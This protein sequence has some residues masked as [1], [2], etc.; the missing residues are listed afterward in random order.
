[1][2][3]QSN[4]DLKMPLG[5]GTFRLENGQAKAS[6]SMALDAGYRHIDTAQIYNNEAEVGEALK[7]SAINRDEIFLTTK[8]WNCHLNQSSF[9][10]S[11]KDSL[12]KL[13]TDHVD[14][15]LIHWPAPQ[16]NESM[17]EYLT[18]LLSA[19]QQGLSKHIG[20]S[21]F[22]IANLK[23]AF[24]T[25]APNDLFTNQVEV[26]PYL[27][28]KIL[29]NFCCNK[30]IHITSYMPFAYGKV[31][32]DPV[33]L[34]LAEKY[35]VSAAEVVIAW[36]LNQGLL[37]IPSSTKK[38]NLHDNLKGLELILTDS[39]IALINTLDRNERLAAPEFSPEW[40]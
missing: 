7:E 35:R 11:V 36:H 33:I 1:M 27:N 5:M 40:D 13:Q 17:K 9:I 4:V 20:V 37:P 2:N 10:S 15:L 31:F 19:Q 30:G 39:D 23:E 29:R 16:H 22:T 28:N 38:A 8:V 26:H 6:V 32:K 21:N 34:S 12:F 25:I 3:Y 24:N 18:Q 14:L